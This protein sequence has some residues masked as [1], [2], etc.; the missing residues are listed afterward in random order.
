MTNLSHLRIYEDFSGAP[1][2]VSSGEYKFAFDFIGG[3][4]RLHRI[5][6]PTGTNRGAKKAIALATH[7]YTSELR[8]RLGDDFDAWVAGNVSLYSEPS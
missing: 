5:A 3:E 1:A 4:A 8:A 7:A 2:I 6:G